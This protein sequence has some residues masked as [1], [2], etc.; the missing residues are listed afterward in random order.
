M[1]IQRGDDGDRERSKSLLLAALGAAMEMGLPEA[2]QILGMMVQEDLL[3]EELR[4]I[5]RKN[6]RPED[7]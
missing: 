7:E 4:E 5:L 1:L 2:E 3:P 6:S